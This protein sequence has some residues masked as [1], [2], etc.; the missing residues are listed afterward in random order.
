MAAL[1]SDFRVA[2]ASSSLTRV[3]MTSVTA[4]SAERWLSGRPPRRSP[5]TGTRGARR[6]TETEMSART[7]AIDVSRLRASVAA[8]ASPG[9]FRGRS[10]RNRS[11]SGPNGPRRLNRVHAKSAS[12]GV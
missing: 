5:A 12:Q 7:R 6:A 8:G 11:G 9:L 4:P 2:Y 3:E 10:R 1:A